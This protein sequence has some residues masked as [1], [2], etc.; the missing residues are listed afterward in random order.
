M[1]PTANKNRFTLVEEPSPSLKNL[2]ESKN[3]P[4]ASP[5][6]VSGGTPS[7]PAV[8]PLTPAAASLSTVIAEAPRPLCGSPASTPIAPAWPETFTNTFAESRLPEHIEH[9]RSARSVSGQQS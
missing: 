7:A 8:R 1:N 5:M 3:P 2:E 6:V 4:P 9:Q